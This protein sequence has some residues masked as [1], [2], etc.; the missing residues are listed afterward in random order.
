M[1]AHLPF[2][3]KLLNT[4]AGR[5]Y[6]FAFLAAYLWI[7]V[8][9]IGARRTLA[10]TLI[11][12]PVAYLSEYA[13]I[14]VGFPY[15]LYHYLDEP[16]ARTELWIGRALPIP[17]YDSLSYTFL[18]YTGY[19]TALFLLTPRL[20]PSRDVQLALTRRGGRSLKVLLAAATLTMLLDVIIDPIAHRGDQWFLGRIYEYPGGGAYFGVPLSN[21]A[22]WWLTSF[23]SVGLYLAADYLMDLSGRDLE[24]PRRYLPSKAL[25]GPALWLGVA[26][27]NIAVTF[28]VAVS[29]PAPT[30]RGQLFALG[31]FSTLLALALVAWILHRLGT[32]R[33]LAT[34]EERAAHFTDYPDPALGRRLG[35]EVVEGPPG[36]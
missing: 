32:A 35:L 11:V 21:F 20:A 26:V 10:F 1:P 6:V 18:N 15:G 22:G 4:F 36:A 33:A 28:V 23:T 31:G 30:E 29:A 16:F 2:F 17:V 24:C 8:H 5:W 25:W 13:S 3:E 9:Q 12:W 27:F 14:R 34:P 7:A 19:A